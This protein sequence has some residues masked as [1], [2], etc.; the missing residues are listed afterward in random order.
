M[1]RSIIYLI[2][3]VC[4][5]TSCLGGIDAPNPQRGNEITFAATLDGVQ[6]KTLYGEESQD[7]SKIKVNWVHN[8]LI[9]VF[10]AECT[11]VPE[12][13]YR[14]ATVTVDANGNE[15]PVSG[16]NSASYLTKTGAAGVQ[17]GEKSESAF[18]AV[19]PS[20]TT[21]TN[22][23]SK[24]D[25]GATVK[26]HIRPVQKNVF[27]YNT[28]RKCWE[29]TPYDQDVNTPTMQD[30]IMYAKTTANAE[31][32]VVNLS[33]KP[34]S[35]VL[36]F[37][38]GGFDY[39]T[40]VGVDQTSVSVRS[41]TLQAPPAVKAIAG[42][43]N[44][45]ISADGKAT[46]TPLGEDRTITIQ[47]D[48]LPLS[49]GQAV[50]FSVYTI[51]YEDKDGNDDYYFGTDDNH[52]WKVRIETT[53]G[54]AFTYKM[55][56]TGGNSSISA[57]KI[58]K[59]SIPSKPITKP[60]DLTG[61]EHNWMEKIPRNVYLSEL[62]LPGSWY[63][64]EEAYS[65]TADLNDLYNGGV[66]AFHINC[67]VSNNELRCAGSD[68][69]VRDIK[70][71]DKLK[72]LN[73]LVAQ[74]SKEYIA[75]VLSIAE[76]GG[77]VNPATVLPKINEM[78]A[79][80]SLTNLYRKE[81]TSN[82]TIADVSGHMIVIVNSNTNKLPTASW[83]N[84]PALIAQA[85]LAL[86]TS[87]DI[88][89]G[90]FKTMQESAMYWGSKATDLRYYYHHAQ[91]TS[92]DGGDHP[93]FNDRRKAI[94]DIISESDDIYLAS[95]HNGWFMMGIGGYLI[96]L[97]AW[98]GF[99][100]FIEFVGGLIGLG[101]GVFGS[102]TDV[103]KNLNNYVLG[104]VNNKL[105]KVEGFYP[106]PVGVVLMNYPLNSQYYGPEL[107]K[108]I[109]NMN[110]AFLLEADPDRDAGTGESILDIE[111]GFADVTSWEDVYLN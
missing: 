34:W 71:A 49:A 54:T 42:D 5:M 58:H 3:V 91:G 8:D 18:Y 51:P 10:G 69:K 105:Q 39:T 53:S 59:V 67:C 78:L 19:Y 109:M 75:V 20:T 100:E 45:A 70:V 72:D 36:K 33:F 94:R 99:G 73:T 77:S 28:E 4:M 47:P 48:Y 110:A 43:F 25:N 64:T 32:N 6:T 24:T 44:L 88:V 90:G 108:A 74:H 29:G 101:E 14:V 7:G 35:T 56:P 41:I 37:R 86:S 63:C 52:L 83:F 26:A 27:K 16:Q 87:G 50:E 61:S 102:T 46:S 9:T 85:S 81:I 79:S 82:T 106:S 17:W 97:D 84:G 15:T 80:T 38:F 92:S 13:E 104:L 60:G 22:K 93:S 66:R 103:A 31:D 23:F 95:S 76:A 111:A 30:A 89:A 96:Y 107:V 12:A 40:N 11:T 65:G 98:G 2:G 21:E 55:R 1:K 68:G 57:G 62:S